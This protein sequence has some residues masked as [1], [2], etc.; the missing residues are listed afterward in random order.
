MLLLLPLLPLLY[1]PGHQAARFLLPFGLW[2]LFR[3]RPA[4]PISFRAMA[5]LKN[6]S[7][8]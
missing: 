2:F 3:T 4:T 1:N 5:A 6:A 8:F 7:P